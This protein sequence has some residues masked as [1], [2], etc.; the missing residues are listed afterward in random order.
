MVWVGRLA[1]PPAGYKC[2]KNKFPNMMIVRHAIAAALSK[3]F[4]SNCQGLQG[5]AP[6]PWDLGRP[7]AAR[8]LPAGTTL[9]AWPG[10]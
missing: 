10:P 5:A 1:Q 8:R 3:G 4:Q 6:F 7:D 9:H 2:K